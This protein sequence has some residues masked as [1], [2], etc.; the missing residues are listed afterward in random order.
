[1]IAYNSISENVSEPRPLAEAAPAGREGSM[2][3]VVARR[4]GELSVIL[5]V[6]LSTGVATDGR[7]ARPQPATR[8][9][10][11]PDI[12]GL[13]PGIPLQEAYKL[14]K[15]YNPKAT[16]KVGQ[17]QP[18]AGGKPV[19]VRVILRSPASPGMDASEII[20]LELTVPPEKPVVWGIL[21]QLTFAA[22]KGKNRAALLA[23]VR[24]KYGQE[25]HG[26]TVP[27]V[28]AFWAFDE[29]GQRAETGG[30]AVSNCAV[31]GPWDI[32]LDPS[33]ARAT[34]STFSTYSALLNRPVPNQGPC[35][36]LVYVKAQFQPATRGGLEI[37]ESTTVAVINGAL[38]ARAQAATGTY[39]ARA[40]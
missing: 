2:R 4:L 8:A 19:P 21:R 11:L 22:G 32:S 3:S 39:R 20:Q 18:E 6:A 28:N 9:A 17:A 29:Q 16:M 36:P 31:P 23:E 15:A 25:G 12:L 7:Q 30:A 13:R 37:I 24:R 40:R 38:A 14:L 27:I 33:E 35:R 5:A 26:L 10:A 34:S 1:L